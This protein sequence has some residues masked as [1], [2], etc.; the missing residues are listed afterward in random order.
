MSPLRTAALVLLLIAALDGVINLVERITHSNLWPVALGISIVLAVVDLVFD[1]RTILG[2]RCH[3]ILEKVGEKIRGMLAFVAA[4]TFGSGVVKEKRKKKSGSTNSG[5][6]QRS[7]AQPSK[8]APAED[9]S[10]PEA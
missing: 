7:E 2:E 9:K 6:S 8:E 4:T 5:A 3:G 1:R 10:A